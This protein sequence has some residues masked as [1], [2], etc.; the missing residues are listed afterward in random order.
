M[1][2]SEHK[3]AFEKIRYN[4]GQEI[5]KIEIENQDGSRADKWTFMK[6]DFPQWVNIIAKKYGIDIKL[7][8]TDLDWAI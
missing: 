5:F 4:S 2:G 6:V 7:K 3:M 8:H 1:G